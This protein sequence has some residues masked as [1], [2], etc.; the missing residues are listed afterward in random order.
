[1]PPSDA[2]RVAEL[3]AQLRRWSHAYHVLDD[4]E[5]DDATYDRGYDQLVALEAAQPELVAPDSPTQRV[6]APPSDRFVKVQ[7]L[8]PVGSLD[9]VTTEEAIRK[10][11]DD[12]RKRLETGPR[13]PSCSSR[14]STGSR[15]T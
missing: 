5:V 6:G 8:E 4:P 15:S 14:R 2:D 12:V 10:W 7:H 13:S 9:K 3:S 1:M 11:A